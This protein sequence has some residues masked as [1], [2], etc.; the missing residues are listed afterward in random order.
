MDVTG[1]KTS[2]GGGNVAMCRIG[3]LSTLLLIGVLGYQYGI[4]Q[5]AQNTDQMPDSAPTLPAAD[6]GSKSGS[7]L[8]PDL[9]RTPTSWS[10]STKTV[11]AAHP[12][13]TGPQNVDPEKPTRPDFSG[14]VPPPST[15][16]P[17]ATTDLPLTTPSMSLHELSRVPVPTPEKK[18]STSPQV[19]VGT[20]SAEALSAA[21]AL[22]ETKGSGNSTPSTAPSGGQPL[23][24]HVEKFGPATIAAGKQVTYEIVAR[25]VGKTPVNNVTVEDEIPAGVRFISADPPG[26]VR[27]DKLAWKLGNLDGGE[28]R[29]IK[30][31]IQAKAEG[32]FAPSATVTFS[33]SAAMKMQ[34]ICPRLS[35]ALT[36]PE[37]VQVG[38]GAEFQVTVT[39]VGT[40]VATNLVLHAS[41]PEGL[42]HVH[43]SHLDA[44]I[45]NLAAGQ[46]KTIP[47]QT[48]A[49]RA[50]SQLSDF[51]V[52]AADGLKASAKA[53]VMVTE[54][55]L[56]LRHAGPKRRYLNREAQ[57]EIELA[58]GG[59]AA[60]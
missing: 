40:G 13:G 20:S 28:Q 23:S 38:D 21:T 7:P 2:S 58:N 14:L 43:G 34:I 10:T 60:A 48:T 54:A 35:M 49:I 26:D 17:P 25:N 27:G 1:Q 57:F 11:P 41:L 5:P 42:S 53:T 12:N 31:E 4:A 33:T 15:F 52:T 3:F 55:V 51:R 59:T 50:G 24:V 37:G 30:V 47:L 19:P 6:S 39:N 9:K 29:R 46:T 22:S 44:E 45:G 8:L 32:E 18:K 56:T 16:V 36:G